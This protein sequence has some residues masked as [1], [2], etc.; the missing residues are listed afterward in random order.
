MCE[1]VCVGVSAHLRKRE[2]ER[3][4]VCVCVLCVYATESLRV[5]C[6][7]Y[8]SVGFS[9]WMCVCVCACERVCGGELGAS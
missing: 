9:N 3:E 6:S 2:R 7:V 8:L 1:S 5:L 4:C